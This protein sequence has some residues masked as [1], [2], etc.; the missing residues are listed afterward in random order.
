[1]VYDNYPHITLFLEEISNSVKNHGN[2]RCMTIIPILFY[3]WKK[4]PTQLRTM[5]MK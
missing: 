4:F 3:S 1:M 2:P 5:A